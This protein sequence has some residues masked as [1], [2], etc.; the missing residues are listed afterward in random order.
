MT[1]NALVS[2]SYTVSDARDAVRDFETAISSSSPAARKVIARLHEKGAT[3][4]HFEISGWVRVECSGLAWKS[5]RFEVDV[6]IDR[7]P[8]VVR[9]TLSKGLSDRHVARS[10]VDVV[11]RCGAGMHFSP[12]SD[13]APVR[14]ARVALGMPAT[15]DEANGLA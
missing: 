12:N 4:E 2:D 15:I 14:A 13:L 6:E 1:A 7:V 5:A 9:V 11:A 8:V 10:I 3:F